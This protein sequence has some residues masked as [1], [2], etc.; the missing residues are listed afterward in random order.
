MWRVFAKHALNMNGRTLMMTHNVSVKL[1]GIESMSYRMEPAKLAQIIITR[2]PMM[3][4]GVREALA[5]LD[6]N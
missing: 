2:V 6:K 1:V 3:I 4:G 5:P